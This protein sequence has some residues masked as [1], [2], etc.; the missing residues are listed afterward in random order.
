VKVKDLAD[1]RMRKMDRELKELRERLNQQ[2]VRSMR[3]DA[4]RV[5]EGL[6]WF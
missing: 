1:D 4:V 2:A 5:C 3:E 6:S